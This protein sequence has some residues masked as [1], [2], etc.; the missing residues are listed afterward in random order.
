M[1]RKVIQFET[2][3]FQEFDPDTGQVWNRS[4]YIA[5]CNDG[6]M[7]AAKPPKKGDELAWQEVPNVPQPEDE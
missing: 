7:W 4:R 5:L 3:L 6:T 2:V 1:P